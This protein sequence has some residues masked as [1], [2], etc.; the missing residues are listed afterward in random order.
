MVDIPLAICLLVEIRFLLNEL[1]V[2]SMHETSIVLCD[3]CAVVE[4]TQSMSRI[5]Y[6]SDDAV[7]LFYYP[8]RLWQEF[9]M[10]V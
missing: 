5:V 9:V 1:H 6:H 7:L 2:L 10:A 8:P 3:R 4:T